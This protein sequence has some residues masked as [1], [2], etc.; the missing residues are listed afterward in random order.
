MTRDLLWFFAVLLAFAAAPV[1]NLT[2]PPAEYYFEEEGP[3]TLEC[4]QLYDE[5]MMREV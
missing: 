2:Q 5:N 4:D 3:S 1:Y